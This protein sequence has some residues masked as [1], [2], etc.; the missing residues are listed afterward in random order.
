MSFWSNTFNQKAKNV[1]SFKHDNRFIW[2]RNKI[3]NLWLIKANCFKENRS[4]KTN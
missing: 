3:I 2:L 1:K 4:N